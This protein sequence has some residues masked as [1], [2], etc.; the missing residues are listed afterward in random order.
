M[1][2]PSLPKSPK[3]WADLKAYIDG[4]F[5]PGY[6]FAKPDGSNPVFARLDTILQR[7]EGTY[8]F[9][10]TVRE[11][12]QFVPFE[13]K[14]F[15]YFN[16]E[17][18]I[19][20]IDRGYEAFYPTADDFIYDF[21]APRVGDFHS[22][23]CLNWTKNKEILDTFTADIKS[24]IPDAKIIYRFDT[25]DYDVFSLPIRIPPFYNCP[26]AMYSWLGV[27]FPKTKAYGIEVD[28]VFSNRNKGRIPN[29][30]VFSKNFN[31]WAK[32]IAHMQSKKLRIG[33][34]GRKDMSYDFINVIN[35]YDFPNPSVAT[36]EMLQAAKF[37]V[38][39]DTGPTHLAVLFDNLNIF[40]F[41]RYFEINGVCGCNPAL[42]HYAHIHPDRIYN[43]TALD[44]DFDNVD[45]LISEVE[46]RF[47]L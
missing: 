28:L 20:C 6:V 31:Q 2:W 25:D 21:K 10:N 40:M 38:G 5:P 35:S 45:L 36:I 39:T 7:H 14:T 11:F 1:R 23:G 18:K 33:A 34:I 44:H 32:F 24:R 8:V 22:G 27:D 13:M 43:S 29:T 47:N 9:A 16:C 26:I 46:K 30:L 37:Y 3:C 15:H 17:R 12:G 4:A 41:K 19:A 42:E